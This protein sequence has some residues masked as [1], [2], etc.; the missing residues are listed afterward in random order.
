LG[1]HYD[2]VKVWKDRE[3]VEDKSLS[4]RP[5]VLS[6]T[7]KA[8]ITKN[9]KEK[10]GGSIRKSVK[11]LNESTRYNR[12]VKK[13]GRNTVRRY[14][15]R[16]YKPSKTPAKPVLSKKNIQDRLKFGDIVKKAGYLETRSRGHQ[17]RSHILFTDETW[18]E[19]SPSINT[20]NQRYYT[21][22]R[23]SFPPVLRPNHGLKVMVE[24]GFCAQG[25]TDLHLVDKGTVNANY[26]KDRILPIYIQSLE[27]RGLFPQTKK[28]TFQQDG[29]TPHTAKIVTTV[30]D[31]LSCEVWGKGVW[32]GNSPDLNPIENL[33]SILKD[34]AHR[35][36][37]PTPKA[38]LFKRFKEEWKKIPVPRL[39]NIAQ[40][41]KTR[42]EEMLD[43]GGRHTRY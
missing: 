41:F 20:Q 32:P 40:S 37:Y 15:R 26:Y 9:L 39:E 35:P 5:T 25:V 31:T 24:G 2:T 3:T 28:V 12:K 6:P 36:P 38:Q 16:K 30:L 27:D 14:I 23:T 34:S 10:V 19:V 21:E 8:Q 1:V 17:K 11:R 7:T 13:I 43:A 42:V 18:L 33:W 4:G 29:A 22:D